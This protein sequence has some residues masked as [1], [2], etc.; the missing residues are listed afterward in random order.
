MAGPDWASR[1]LSTRNAVPLGEYPDT[2]LAIFLAYF[3][4]KENFYDRL[5]NGTASCAPA[6][7]ATTICPCQGLCGAWLGSLPDVD[8]VFVGH[9]TDNVQCRA[10][11]LAHNDIRRFDTRHC[12]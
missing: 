1:G 4:K 2:T 12:H 7:L 11:A 10:W 3:C 8:F 5:Q 6:H 9:R